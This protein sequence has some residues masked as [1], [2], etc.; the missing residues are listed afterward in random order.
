MGIFNRMK[1]AIKSSAN[2]AVEKAISPEKELELIIDELE[3]QRKSA[4]KDLLSYKTTAKQMEQDMAVLDEKASKWEKRAMAAVKR[5]DD[6]TARQCLK[7]HREALA[8]KKRVVADRKEAAGYA[9]ELNKSRKKVEHRLKILKLKKGTMASQIAMARGKGGPLDGNNELF[10]KLDRAAEAIDD[11]AIAM[12][13]N[14]ALEGEL[15]ETPALD[16]LLSSEEKS[17]DADDELAK[18]KKEMLEA[19]KAKALPAAEE[20]VAT[21][22]APADEAE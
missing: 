6:E 13:V 10:E 14:A 8:E 19:K 7:E 9:A 18:L 1:R 2:A 11:E 15:D 4:Y 17:I 5:G 12:E 20:P 22:A 21:D 16:S 3:E